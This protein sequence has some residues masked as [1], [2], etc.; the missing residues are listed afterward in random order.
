MWTTVTNVPYHVRLGLAVFDLL[1]PEVRQLKQ[2]AAFRAARQ[3][4][5][6]V[7]ARSASSYLMRKE[8][9]A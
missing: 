9:R 1:L 5:H 4:H 3:Q 6:I 8:Q 2:V 7:S